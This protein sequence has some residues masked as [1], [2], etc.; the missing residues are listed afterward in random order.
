MP[1]ANCLTIAAGYRF[2]NGVP[3][4][5]GIGAV[6]N[7]GPPAVVLAPDCRVLLGNRRDIHGYPGMLGGRVMRARLKDTLSNGERLVHASDEVRSLILHI[8]SENLLF[9]GIEPL[10]EGLTL[11]PGGDGEI[12]PF[13]QAGKNGSPQRQQM[14][15]IPEDTFIYVVDGRSAAVKLACVDGLAV[16]TAVEIP[17]AVTFIAKRA[18][19]QK[20]RAALTWGVRNL[21]H[22]RD[23][24]VHTE[25]ARQSIMELNGLLPFA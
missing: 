2:T 21:E 9:E 8:R 24:G 1:L 19:A 13:R 11:R 14:Y 23:T 15:E 6:M 3:M 7:E 18:R 4:E 5:S 22:L 20:S 10:A 16:V 25:Q 12:Q 17:E